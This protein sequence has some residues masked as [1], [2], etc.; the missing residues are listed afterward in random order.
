MQD[1]TIVD[2]MNLKQG[3]DE[4]LK[5]SMDRYQKTVQRVKNISLKL[6]VQYVMHALRPGLF[7]GS[8][9]RPP[10]KTMEELRQ[11]AED[12]V[13]VKDMKQNYRRKKQEAKA[14]RTDG[15]KEG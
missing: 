2:L 7:K 4:S 8:V 9:Y 1:I 10:P 6:V 14:D 13:R 5:A 11:R 3:K 12:E 15:K